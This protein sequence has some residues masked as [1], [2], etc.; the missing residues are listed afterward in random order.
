MAMTDAHV[1]DHYAADYNA[2]VD[3]AIAASGESVEFFA[4]LKALLTRRALG[5][6]HPRAILDFGCGIGNTTRALC[7]VFPEAHVIGF[8][9]SRESLSVAQQ[10]SSHLGTRVRFITSDLPVLPF[11]DSEFDLAFT[12]CVFHHIEKQEHAFWARE[13]RRVLRPA[14]P[15]FFFEHNPYNPLTVR[16]VRACPFDEGVELVPPGYATALMTTAGLVPTPPRYYFF[17]PRLLRFLRLF[18]TSLQ[19]LP[20]GGQYFVVAR[21][22]IDGNGVQVQAAS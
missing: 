21:R 17:F 2:T 16:V 11:P 6:Q 20:L 8:D 18:E 4:R 7:A 5:S 12:S 19:W 22:P 3:A 1:F 10:L 9:L 14:A 15:L 13:L